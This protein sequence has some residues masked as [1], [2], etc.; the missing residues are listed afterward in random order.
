VRLPSSNIIRILSFAMAAG[1][2]LGVLI[3]GFVRVVEGEGTSIELAVPLALLVGGLIGLAFMV[4]IKLALRQAAYDLHNY[5]VDLTDA[6]LPTPVAITGDEVVYMRETLS[7]A[8]AFVP[9]PEV[10]P[11]LADD[12]AAAPDLPAQLAAVAHYVGQHLPVSGALLLLLDAERSVLYPEASCGAAS[13]GRD[14]AIDLYASAIGR[15]LQERRPALYSGLEAGDMLPVRAA[16]G[17]PSSIYC[18][19]LLVRNQ[20]LG[21]LALAL[22]IADIRL[23]DE[24]RGFARAVAD[25]FTLAAQGGMHRRLFERE[26]D[27]L[28]AFEQLGALIADSERFE[29]ALEQVLRVAARVTDSAHGSLLLLDA[30]ETRV[31][32]RITLKAGDV[33]PLSVTAGPILKHGLAGWALRERRADI[34]DD[35]E[36]DT[37]WLP[38]PGLDDMR[39]AMVVPLLYGERILGLLTLADPAPRH[40][41]RR[42]LALAA[43]LAAHAVTVLARQQREELVEPGEAAVARRLL[44]GRLAPGRLAE[45]AAD[46]AALARALDPWRGPVI[47]LYVG[48]RGLDAAVERLPAADLLDELLAPWAAELSAA[49]HQQSGMIARQDDGGLLAVFGYPLAHPDDRARALRAALEAQTIARRMRGRWRNQFGCE[50][51]ASV[52]L[53]MGEA[54]AGPVGEPAGPEFVILGAAVRDARR[55]QQ[56]ARPDEVIVGDMAGEAGFA[57]EPLAPL[58]MADGEPPRPIFRLAPGR[59]A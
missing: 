55:L 30:D 29:R 27:R 5:A 37:R 46:P 51:A 41:S 20:P 1:L 57:L 11:L 7:Q 2:G 15:A 4:G 52:G 18:L 56:L 9:R 31:R 16:G 10:F 26:G 24:Q 48:L 44:E 3:Y 54:V 47:A 50:L 59:A 23:N 14:V 28:A 25:L 13:V 36:R 40:Y 58:T 32:V 35:T 17:A 39:S 8:L 33:L 38:V 45:L 6:Q 49:V 22:P 19:P 12:L 21:V 42:S 34:I 43:A 53:A